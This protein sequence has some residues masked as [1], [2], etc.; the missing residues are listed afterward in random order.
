MTECAVEGCRDVG[1][2]ARYSV[3]S[4]ATAGFPG[5]PLGFFRGFSRVSWVFPGGFPGFSWGFPEF[6][7]GFPGFS[8]GFSHGFPGVFLGFS[9][10]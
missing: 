4:T 9:K 1:G 7:R 2:L 5:V 8:R 10:D 6:S 3:H